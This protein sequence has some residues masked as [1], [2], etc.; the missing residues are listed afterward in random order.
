MF[1]FG[2]LFHT[3]VRVPD[4]DEAMAELGDGLGLTWAEAREN[5]A[6]TL[7]TPTEGLQEIHLRYTYSA[8]GPQH[9]ELLEG[10]AGSF[11]DGRDRTG[12]HHLGVWVDDL[13][14]ETD[15][16]VGKGWTLVGA[17]RDPGDGEGFGVFTY[18]QPPTG[19]IVELVDR[20]VLPFFEQ[21]WNA[22]LD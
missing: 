3:G 19:L 21:W 12:A 7:W 13:V 15:R 20:T 22:A 17:Q 16:L 14:G 2:D 9:V 1:D 10:P 18:V 8:E 4:L 11:W 5:P 6:Q